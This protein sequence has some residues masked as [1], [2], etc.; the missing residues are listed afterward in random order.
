[1]R[2]KILSKSIYTILLTIVF[3]IGI[4]F[5]QMISQA[6]I[7]PVNSEQFS[8]SQ[9]WDLW[10]SAIA[11]STNLWTKYTQKQS[12]PSTIY[13]DIFSVSDLIRATKYHENKLIAKNYIIL[14]EYK[15]ILKTDFKQLLQ[16]TN[17]KRE[18]LDG[19]LW[20][21][22]Y[23]YIQANKNVKTLL[24]QRNILLQVMTSSNAKIWN[25][26]LKMD[27]D[28]KSLDTNESYKNISQYV[29][30]KEEYYHAKVFI[31]YINVIL[32]DY[33]K[34]NNYN[35]VLLDTLINNKE[36]IIKE[37]YVVLPDSGT[38]LLDDFN[39]LYTEEQFKAKK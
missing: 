12:I 10:K 4:Q 17:N 7:D 2:S 37:A 24:E 32:K 5:S 28:Y 38:Q 11:I 22:E 25:L 34:M 13:R 29:K 39:L 1:M 3:F 18:I 27:R 19:I 30:Y 36:A 33:S 6:Q 15:N 21:L 16:N 26:K 35:K 14:R 20:Q 9:I 31:T 23:R 8:N